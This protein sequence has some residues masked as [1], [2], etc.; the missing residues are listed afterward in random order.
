MDPLEG[1][2][3]GLMLN[4]DNRNNCEGY[5][6]TG[7]SN[8]GYIAMGFEEF[9]VGDTNGA[10]AYFHA[11]LDAM[12]TP[13]G[14][15][16]H[17]Y[18]GKELFFE[19]FRYLT[20]QGVYNGHNGWTD[21]GTTNKKNVD[22]DNPGSDWDSSLEMPPASWPKYRTPLESGGECSKI[23]T[24]N[25]MFQVSNQDDHSDDAIEA[26]VSSGGFGSSQAKFA[27]V[28]QYMYDADLADGNYG[29]APNLPDQ[30]NVTS[31]FLIDPNHINTTTIG[32]AD[33]GG[34]GA[35]LELSEN[36]DEL[37]A[38][39]EE[40]FKQILSVS[41]TFVAASV[42]VNVFNRAEITDNVYIALF[43]VDKDARPAW[44]GNVKKLKLIG[45]NSSSSNSAL[46]DALGQGAVAGDGRLR[47]DAL[48]HWTSPAELPIPD[49]STSEVA[50]RDGRS[51]ARGGAGQKI[52]GF[53]SGSPQQAN[54]L[55]GR[56]IY[57]DAAPSLLASLNVDA[58]V[59][60]QLQGDLDAADT[61]EAMDLLKYAR[62]LDVDD[63]DG[64][65]VTNEAR[66]WIFGDALHSRPMP[67]NYGARGGY[68]N[69][70]PAIYVAVGSND[71]MLRMI[72]NTSPG[73]TESGEEVWAFMPRSAM[74]TQKVLRN[75]A[76]GE[77]HPYGFDGAPVAYIQDVDFDGD[78]EAGD[79]V[80]LFLGNLGRPA[81]LPQ[82][83][84]GADKGR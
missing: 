15:M 38:T 6:R 77:K 67:L 37:V 51:V 47:F 81:L 83:G 43:Q 39:L 82:A 68:S 60:G 62:G 64:N 80:W 48:T 18:Q 30:Q 70:N 2:K 71:G 13:Q 59:A 27:N 36:P 66:E 35:P 57:Y 22:F 1:V 72:R 24:V 49:T 78:I 63:L 79:K 14:N 46:L 23:F 69:S 76:G 3:V 73:G 32:Y 33:A 9:E 56:T 26:A 12:P 42:P 41:T 19:F 7:C 44:V 31:Y 20:G 16:S 65:S 52:P 55:G 8:G 4:H 54:G 21:Y 40:I 50:G 61:D 5:G 29:T 10:K 53:L 17:S 74:A 45:A 58:G 84:P 11:I 25:S 28:I 34:T 75:N